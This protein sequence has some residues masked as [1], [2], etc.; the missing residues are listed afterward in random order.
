M[1]A[2]EV[3]EKGALNSRRVTAKVLLQGTINGKRAAGG[4]LCLRAR[5]DGAARKVDKVACE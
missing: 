3:Q 2:Q 4:T 5:R 1:Q